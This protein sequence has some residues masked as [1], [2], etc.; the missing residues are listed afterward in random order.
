MPILF[1]FKVFSAFAGG[2][3]ERGINGLRFITRPGSQQGIQGMSSFWR[4][5]SAGYALRASCQPLAFAGAHLRGFGLHFFWV[6]HF[7]TS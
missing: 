7:F 1:C 4:E 6:C 2:G 3:N 5:H